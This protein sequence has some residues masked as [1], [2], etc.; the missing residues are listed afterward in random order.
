MTANITLSEAED[1]LRPPV[2]CL[3]EICPPSPGHECSQVHSAQH[4][5]EGPPDKKGNLIA[6]L[7]TEE[8]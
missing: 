4:K 5:G 2:T 6:R 3:G 7:M 1:S 8:K